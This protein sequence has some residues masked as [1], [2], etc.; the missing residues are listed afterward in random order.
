MTKEQKG[1]NGLQ[2][3]YLSRRPIRLSNGIIQLIAN[4]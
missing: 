1:P 2:I 3:I 4:G